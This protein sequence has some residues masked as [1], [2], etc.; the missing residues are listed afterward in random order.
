MKKSKI[1]LWIMLSISITSFADTSCDP[2]TAAMHKIRELAAQ[3]ST[4][5]GA[6]C[7]VKLGDTK[8]ISDTQRIFHF[9][10][11]KCGSENRSGEYLLLLTSDHGNWIGADY[12]QVGRDG[13]FTIDFVRVLKNKVELVGRKWSASDKHCC[14][15][16]DATRWVGFGH[17][18]LFLLS[19]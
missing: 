13:E 7:D 4:T 1:L 15:T 14:P 12:I 11:T 16:V 19:L 9:V 18:Q 17:N 8:T 6:S 5:D 2:H 3:L 10:L